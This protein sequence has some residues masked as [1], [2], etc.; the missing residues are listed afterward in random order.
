MFWKK[1]HMRHGWDLKW[2]P[3][4][5]E[6]T[7]IPE[8]WVCAKPSSVKLHILPKNPPQKFWPMCWNMGRSSGGHLIVASCTSAIKMFCMSCGFLQYVIQKALISQRPS[9]ALCV[10]SSSLFCLL[11]LCWNWS[12]A[13][14]TLHVRATWSSWRMW[15]SCAPVAELLA[16]NEFYFSGH[17]L[18]P[19]VTVTDTSVLHVIRANTSNPLRKENYIWRS[20]FCS[21]EE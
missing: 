3:G 6:V 5:H 14:G 13:S 20:L 11:C 12:K 9:A 15:C 18:A 19:A 4:V 21:T 1:E 2:Q 8:H 16:E 17:S 7:V 10:E